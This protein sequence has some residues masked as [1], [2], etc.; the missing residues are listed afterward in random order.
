VVPGS[1]DDAT[2]FGYD[3]GAQMIGMTAPARRVGIFLG[4]SGLDPQVVT[5]D[6]VAM[7][8]ASVDWL[9]GR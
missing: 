1:P 2:L 3:K 4:D 9:L 8:D 5:P 7:F 6:A